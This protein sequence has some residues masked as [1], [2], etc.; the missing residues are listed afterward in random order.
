MI[1]EANLD[2]TW[3]TL[4]GGLTNYTFTETGGHINKTAWDALSSGT[5]LITFYGNDTVGN[6]GY[7]IVSILRDIDPP[8]SNL[9]FTPYSG[10]NKVSKSTSFVLNADDGLGS[11]VS[12][13]RYRI[14][15]QDWI[16][17]VGPFYLDLYEYGNYT[18]SY[19]SLDMMNNM[20]DINSFVVQLVEI[21]PEPGPPFEPDILLFTIIGVAVGGVA[22]AMMITIIL[23]RRRKK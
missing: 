21:P 9:S 14:N 1:L 6:T 19:Y 4:D 20:E 7:V 15:Y 8:S 2:S 13:I 17:Y 3:Y 5:V 22:I 23:L 11:G 12:V 10:T 16:D 18:I